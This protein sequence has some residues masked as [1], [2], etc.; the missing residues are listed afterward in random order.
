MGRSSLGAARRGRS[1]SWGIRAMSG[2]FRAMSRSLGAMSRSLRAMRRSLRTAGHLTR[3]PDVSLTLVDRVPAMRMGDCVGRRRSTTSSACGR[4]AR[5]CRRRRRCLLRVVG[6]SHPRIERV[7]GESVGDAGRVLALALALRGAA[8]RD[9]RWGR[10][11]V[12]VG[13]VLSTA[14]GG[15][16]PGAASALDFGLGLAATAVARL[17][18]AVGGA[19]VWVEG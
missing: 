19:V 4:S 2:S 17:V 18:S 15:G 7:S 5:R 13:V 6:I 11:V 16:S 3:T 8:G 14:G 12:A 9:H 10:R 1:M